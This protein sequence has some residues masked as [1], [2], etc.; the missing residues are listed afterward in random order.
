MRFDRESWRKLYVAESA[1]H[2]MLPVLARGLRDYLIRHAKEDGTLLSRTDDPGNDLARALG[3]HPEELETVSE[4]VQKWIEDGYLSFKRRRLWITNYVDAQSSQSPAA[5]RQK[6][7]RDRNRGHSPVTGDVTQASPGDV[8]GESRDTSH[9]TRPDPTRNDETRREAQPVTGDGLIPCPPLKQLLT[10]EQRASLETSMVP[11]WAIDAMVADLHVALAGSSKRMALDGWHSYAAKAITR[12][13]NN[14]NE[15]PKKPSPA[16]DEAEK[17]RII[18]EREAHMQREI[19][20]KRA[21]TAEAV[22]KARAEGR[23]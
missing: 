16:L 22:A 13:W 23:L 19:E 5:R 20:A 10:R 1:E 6:R 2:R 14:P 3:A 18:A 9:P 11:D 17:R 8:T 15:R 12:R 7:Y 21:R 4:F